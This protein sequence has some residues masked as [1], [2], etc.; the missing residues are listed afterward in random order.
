[1]ENKQV[2]TFQ[3]EKVMKTTKFLSLELKNFAVRRRIPASKRQN[4]SATLPSSGTEI[5]F[6]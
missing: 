6:C 2:F 1:M 4:Q 5:S 3:T